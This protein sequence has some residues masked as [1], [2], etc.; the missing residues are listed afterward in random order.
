MDFF[1][2]LI[3]I[4]I[5]IFCGIFT[6]LLPGIHINLISSMLLINVSFILN[7]FQIDEISVFILSMTITHT[8]VDFIPS[9]LFG[10]PNPDTTL[11]ILPGHRLSIKGEAYKAIFLSS[12]G[13]LLGIIFAFIL[14]II[15]FYI[16]ENVYES[17]KSF[18]PLILTIVTSYFIIIEKTAKKRFLSLLIVFFSTGLGLLALN[19]T[20]VDNPLLI[21]FSGIFGIPAIISALLEENLKFP[22][23]DLKIKNFKFNFDVIKAVITGGLSSA[24]CSITPGVGNAQ[25]ATIS[26]MFSK[27]IDSENFIILLGS[28]NTINFVLSIIA[29]YLIERARNGSILAIS[30]LMQTIT[31]ETMIFFYVLTFIIGIVAFFI[32]LFIGKHLIKIVSKMNFRV[33]NMC[34]LVFILILITVLTGFNGL[35]IL[36]CS[37]FL[38]LLCISIDVKR[39][40][41]MTVLTVPIILNLI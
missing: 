25:A 18:I 29:F 32:T 8:F 33:I 16:L 20:M 9:V 36:M 11:S 31:F 39:I 22:K 37:V 23:Q 10:I 24:I 12:I 5:G 4:I 3:A 2:L 1:L 17:V 26:A 27:D 21:L 14:S 41:L 19:T 28:I 30:Q 40:H 6:G 34:I 35:L 7:Y 15:S 38:G 13:S